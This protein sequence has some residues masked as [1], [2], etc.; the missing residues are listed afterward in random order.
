[1][2][3]LG[4]ACNLDTLCNL[5]SL[6]NMDYF[7]I[8]DIKKYWWSHFM[9]SN[10]VSEDKEEEVEVK[11]ADDVD[12]SNEPIFSKPNEGENS[13]SY[14]KILD[15]GVALTNLMGAAEAEKPPGLAMWK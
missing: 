9:S 15:V 6:F 1:M 4:E 14:P 2:H 7:D 3:L 5:P 13:I 10:P 8:M 11:D 12:D